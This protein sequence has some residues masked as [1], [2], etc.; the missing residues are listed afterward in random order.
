MADPLP[1]DVAACR[2][3]LVVAPAG[4]GKTHMITEAVQ[5]CAGRQLVLTHTHAG[6]KAIRDRMARFCVPRERYL[7]STLDS[8]AL[9]YASAFPSLSGWT[10]QQP[11]GN[12]WGELQPCAAKLF[13]ENFVESVLRASY[14]GVFVDEYQ[15]CTIDQHKLVLELASV[16]PCRVFGDPLQSVFWEVNKGQT[17]PW[18][19]V[20]ENF[21]LIGDL[22]HPH[23]WADRNEH[24]G[25]WLLEIRPSLLAGS[26]IELSKAPG[27]TVQQCNPDQ[28]I[29]LAACLN[30][31][32]RDDETIIA[33]R[34]WRQHCHY[35][36]GRLNNAF[37]TFE[38]AQCEDLLGWTRKIGDA[39]G[40][41]RVRGLITFAEKWLTKL[42][43]N[44]VRAVGKSVVDNRQNR[45]RR[46]DLIRLFDSLASVR[47]DSNALRIVAVLDA[48]ES[49]QERPVFK[50][51]EVWSGL[52]K[53]ASSSNAASGQSLFEV[54][55]HHRDIIRRSGRHPA[56]HCLATPLL[57]KGLEC[58]RA[59]ILDSRDFPDAES[60]YVCLTRACKSITI[61]TPSATLKTYRAASSQ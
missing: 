27:V 60:L 40:S 10:T 30:S 26:E 16:L 11:H 19:R 24:L 4:C 13:K 53:A 1:K 8:F 33:F 7:V 2:R 59:L 56:K 38:D 29:Q 50:S 36:A 12:E 5:C 57:V 35:L 32:R 15:D 41:D 6:V 9:R 14:A 45:A 28:Q 21:S 37:N 39:T 46:D 52:R 55:W 48:F 54:A 23:R 22:N 34:K 18:N 47:D 42:P 25:R 3:G 44:A 49:L 17:L 58:D 43:T 20:E 51:R 61:L 31:L